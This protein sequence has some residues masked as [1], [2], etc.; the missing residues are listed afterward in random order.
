[1]YNVWLTHKLNA[2]ELKGNSKKPKGKIEDPPTSGGVKRGSWLVNRESWLVIRESWVTVQDTAFW[3]SRP[4]KIAQKHPTTRKNMQKK[5]QKAAKKRQN[6]AN[7]PP[8]AGNP[9]H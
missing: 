9:K 7:P 5:R 3:P 2:Y 8:L 6:K 4:E 1:L